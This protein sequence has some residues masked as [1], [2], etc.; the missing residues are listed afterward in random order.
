MPDRHNST[1][2]SIPAAHTSIPPGFTFLRGPDDREY[3]VPDFY[4]G[5]TMFAWE[6]NEMK[7][8]LEVDSASR[9]VSLPVIRP[10]DFDGLINH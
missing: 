4:A 6:H 5:E 3:L 9:A 8:L 2:S 10:L 1:T 7:E